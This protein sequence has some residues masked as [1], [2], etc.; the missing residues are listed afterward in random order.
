MLTGSCSIFPGQHRGFSVNELVTNSLDSAFREPQG[1]QLPGTS[2]PP[3]RSLLPGV[4]GCMCWWSGTT[5]PGC[6]GS[7]SINR[8]PRSQTG[9]LPRALPTEGTDRSRFNRRHEICLQVPGSRYSGEMRETGPR[10]RDRP[11]R[12][13]RFPTGK[14]LKITVPGILW[15]RII[16]YLT[17]PVRIRRP[18]GAGYNHSSSV[19]ISPGP[20]PSPVP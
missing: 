3:S 4:R 2:P 9:E 13:D 19:E 11:Y 16:R 10:V 1:E 8:D 14:I 20:S 12:L 6:P 7:T 18:P 5:G 17:G 15:F